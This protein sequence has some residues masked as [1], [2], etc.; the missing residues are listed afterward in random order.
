MAKED[1]ML[2]LDRDNFDTTPMPGGDGHLTNYRYLHKI[3]EICAEHDIRLIGLYFPVYKP[4]LFYDQ[5]YYYS[6]L[7]DSFPKLEVH[8]YSHLD[9]PDSCRFDAHHLNWN[10]AQVFTRRLMKDF[11][12]K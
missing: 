2:S 6:A 3:M 10:G 12:F 8:D 1:N 11:N 7:R 4:E 5:Q 9:L